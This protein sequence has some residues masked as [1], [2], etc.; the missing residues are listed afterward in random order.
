MKLS[1]IKTI[2]PTLSELRFRLENGT[3]VPD[4]FHVTEVGQ[5]TK[6]FMDCGGTERIEKTVSFQL[7]TAQDVEHRL[8]PAKLLGIIKL[9]ESKIGLADA[10]VEVEYQNETIGRYG[11]D[12]DGGTF[13]LTNKSTA[14]LAE[15][16]C[17]IAPLPEEEN[18]SMA[19]NGVA[20]AC[21]APGSG[22]C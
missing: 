19:N 5:V 10:E 9:S 12:F 4:H 14:C 20:P 3:P 6:H 21:C 22:P 7:W 2:L 17:G 13:V 11:L 15:M 18:I 1:Q 8:R 16:A